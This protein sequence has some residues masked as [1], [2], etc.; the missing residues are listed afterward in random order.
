MTLCFLP[1]RKS[2]MRKVILI[3]LVI[4]L[5]LIALSL[6][7]P[8]KTGLI[9][10][11]RTETEDVSKTDLVV[12]VLR[13]RLDEF[14]DPA[15]SLQRIGAGLMILKTPGTTDKERA[16]GIIKREPVFQLKLLADKNKDPF[17]PSSYGNIVATSGDVKNV[18]VIRNEDGNP[19]V[20][21]SLKEQAWPAFAGVTGGNIGSRIGVF[22]DD[23]LITAPFI[24]ESVQDG[25]FVI[26]GKFTYPEATLMRDMIRAFV[27]PIPFQV[28]VREG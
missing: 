28:T 16:L 17:D 9:F 3:I 22:L 7:V 13:E 8:R 11:I 5:G 15:I 25:R 26:T 6:L 19:N 12:E 27:F 1:K 4:V 14:N 23:R 10:E 21:I 18:E 2:V 20:M 24:R